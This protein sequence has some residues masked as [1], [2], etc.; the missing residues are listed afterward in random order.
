[1]HRPLVLVILMHLPFVIPSR[2]AA[3]DLLVLELIDQ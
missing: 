1:M 2:A 3:R